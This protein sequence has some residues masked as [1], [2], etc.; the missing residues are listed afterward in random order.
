MSLRVL[1]IGMTWRREVLSARSKRFF[2]QSK[3]T[4]PSSTQCPKILAANPRILWDHPSR[5][6]SAVSN[7]AAPSTTKPVTESQR[8]SAQLELDHMNRSTSRLLGM[9]LNE[10]GGA[11]V[12]GAI[13]NEARVALHYWSR[14]WYMHFHPGF[15][16][17]AKGSALSLNALRRWDSENGGGAGVIA[18]IELGESSD[19][20]AQKLSGD[21]GA[22][23][24]ERLLDWSISNGLAN[25]GLFDSHPGEVS[26]MEKED[27]EGGHLGISP[28]LMCV[29]IMETYLLPTAYGGVGGWDGGYAAIGHVAGDG[30][31]NGTRPAAG[32]QHSATLL[33]HFTINSSYV[34][35]VA[36]TTRLMKKMK[37]LQA[38]FPDKLSPDTLSI[39]A[40][41]NTWSK[42]AIVFQDQTT[43]GAGGIVIDGMA[44]GSNPKEVLKSLEAEGVCDDEAEIYGEDAYT[45]R[46]C[47]DRMESIVAEAE[48]RY[49][50]MK[51]D[52]IRPSV[53]WYNT[54]MGA[55][56]RSDLEGAIDKAKRILHGME[57]YDDDDPVADRAN[58][59]FPVVGDSRRCWASPDTVSYNSVLFCLARDAGNNR[60]KEA[61][62]LLQRMKDRYI[63]TKDEDM[64]PDEL[65]YGAVLHTLAQAGMA[66]EAE[67]ILDSLEDS[68]ERDNKGT[69][70]SLTIYNTV[71]NAWANSLRRDAPRRAE[72]LLE[73]MKVLSSTGKNPTVE[74]DTI[75]IS[76]VISCHARSKTRRGAERGEQILYEALELYSEGNPRVKPD[77]IMFNCAITGWTNISG[78]ENDQEGLSGGEI[79]AERAEKLLRKMKDDRLDV[80][81]VAQTFNIV[82]D[83]WAKSE[84]KGATERALRLMREMPDHGVTPDECSYNSVLHSMT[85]E[86]DSKWVGRAEEMF[87]EMKGKNV[88]TSEITYHVMMNIYGKSRDGEGARKAEE[89]LRSMVDEKLC[90]NDISYN[91]CI[92]ACARRGDHKMAERLLEEMISLSDQGKSKCRPTIHSFASVVNA[93]A[94]SGDV[95]AV[96]CAKE[97]VRK[98]EELEYVS[99]NSI[100]YNSLIDCIVKSGQNDSASQAEDILVRME[101]MHRSGNPDVRPNSYAYSMVLTSC[102]RSKEPGAAERAERLL[103]NMESLYADGLSDVVANSR[104]YSAAMTAWARSS[105]P[106]AIERT[107]ALIDRM[108]QNGRNCTPHGKPNAH[109]Y[110]ACIHAIAKSQQPGK[111]KRCGEVLERMIAA[112]NSGF[113]ESAPSLITY[114]TIINACAYTHGSE[115]DKKEAFDLARDCFRT[116]LESNEL[117][118]CV[119]SFTNFFLVISRHLKHGAVRD[120]FAEAVFLEGCKRGKIGKQV[121]NNF[122]KASPAVANRILM[123]H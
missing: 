110:N 117:E 55:W 79:P 61:E 58:D 82:L 68:F 81:L 83:C 18:G 104:C 8:R 114:S 27:K 30:R 47:L 94:K 65:T 26:H 14:R 33:K 50:S 41:L 49:V 40:E 109:C 60:A 85:K 48:E 113:H 54:V 105:S 21:H 22:R 89:L 45:L 80:P 5:H 67:S 23:Q 46:G 107:L 3:W 62:A 102:A 96:A 51:D 59:R 31:A 112:R 93:L 7:A 87:K 43:N 84:T 11:S 42:R 29:N 15:G 99:P 36:D 17:A 6:L 2:C 44:G 77:S 91:I 10:E 86:S 69:V 4:H 123:E 74:P 12:S 1:P 103:L 73:R 118:P 57:G 25:H 19:P 32:D 64:R 120:Q 72:S 78:T 24:A 63:R 111:A 66:H 106:D 88:S 37:R 115:S 20:S 76:S 95:D 35:A 39:K 13:V 122:R 53:D 101:H 97:V 75:S 121:F 119:S 52:R 70:P 108:E 90:P 92:D 100:L 98:V 16:R 28:N 38:D 34:R 9:N 56:A 116:L 71:L